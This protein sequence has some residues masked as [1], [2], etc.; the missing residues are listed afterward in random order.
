MRGQTLGAAVKLIIFA[1][2]TILAT[3]VLGVVVSNRTFGST[4]TY[5]AN[6]SDVTDL[7]TGSDVRMAGVRVG[8]VKSIKSMSS[9][10]NNYAQVSFTVD[11]TVP[12]KTTTEVKVQYLNLV[13]QRYLNLVSRPGGTTLSTKDA[14]IPETQTSPALDLTAL[15]NGFKPLFRALSPDD[16]NKF[17]LEIIKTLQGEGGTID[18]LLK[19]TA[20]LTNT[21]AQRDAAIGHVIDNLLT[22]LSTVQQRDKGLGET[23]DQLQRLVTGLAGDRDAISSALV[24]LNDL[25]TSSSK[26]ITGIRPSL[27]ADLRHLTKLASNLN[28]TKDVVDKTQNA[29]AAWLQREPAKLTRIIRTGSYGG[30]FNFWL[31]S[32]AVVGLP[33]QLQPAAS[34]S[35]SCPAAS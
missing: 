5:K 35:P 8:T 23:V 26:L 16:V 12:M 2:V 32:A 22:V 14:V 11:T 9:G 25:A 24:N 30:Y 13:G 4:H 28:N 7:I 34:Q 15:F 17:A 10:S 3:A 21:V 29:L 31:C 19:Q 1:V 27:P 18:S 6:F 33:V 20:S